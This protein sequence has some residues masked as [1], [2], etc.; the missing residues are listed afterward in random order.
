MKRPLKQYTR[1]CGL[2]N[3]TQENIPVYSVTNSHGFVPSTDY[4]PKRCIAKT[5][6]TIKL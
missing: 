1:E 6:Q 5:S 3:K 2:R 4:F